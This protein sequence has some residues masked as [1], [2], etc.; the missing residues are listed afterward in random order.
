MRS[1]A[2]S[3]P[4]TD[5]IRKRIKELQ[6][7]VPTIV[8]PKSFC[9]SGVETDDEFLG[10]GMELYVDSIALQIRAPIE[11]EQDPPTAANRKW[12]DTDANGVLEVELVHPKGAAGL[13]VGTKRIALAS[14]PVY[15]RDAMLVTIRSDGNV[16]DPTLPLFG[17]ARVVWTGK[18]SA[19]PTDYGVY[20][21]VTVLF[22]VK[23]EKR[24]RE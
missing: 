15:E 13:E 1:V 17:R 19:L 18:S 9:V 14:I 3:D 8:V 12:S 24:K 22:A 6:E 21:D 5:L 4:L 16:V 10:C 7:R 23:A 2:P 20:A 11:T